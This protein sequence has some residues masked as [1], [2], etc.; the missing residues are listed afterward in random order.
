MPEGITDIIQALFHKTAPTPEF[1]WQT[2]E[3]CH[4]DSPSTTLLFWLILLKIWE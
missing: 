3:V 4:F 2:P 1:S